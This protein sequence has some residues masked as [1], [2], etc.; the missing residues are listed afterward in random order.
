M[1]A[2]IP[3]TGYTPSPP[4]RVTSSWYTTGTWI[5]D[6][7]KTTSVRGANENQAYDWD[8]SVVDTY[9]DLI[10]QGVPIPEPTTALPVGLGL[11]G[12]GVIRSGS[13]D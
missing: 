2:M 13:K 10:N 4:I 12:L 9:A 5:L 1:R 7:S 11:V 3:L 6:T 8:A